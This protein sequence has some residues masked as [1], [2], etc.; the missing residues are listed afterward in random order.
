MAF[1]LSVFAENKPGK[2]E[3]ITKILSEKELNVRGFSIASAGDFGVLKII[4]DNPE[5]AYNILKEN[6]ITV[7]KRKIIAVQID[8][9]PGSLHNLLTILSEN[10]INIEDCYGISVAYN[11]SAAII[12]E[13]D[14]FPETETILM[15]N[16]IKL[17]SDKEIYSI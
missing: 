11:K 17:L 12:L 10:K 14:E 9:K 2:L 16:N 6:H 1:Q 15:K 8:D 4:V 3:K 13:I 5:M 7:S